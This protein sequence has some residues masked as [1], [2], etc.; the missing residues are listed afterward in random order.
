MTGAGGIAAR[1]DPAGALDAYARALEIIEGLAGA[2]GVGHGAGNLLGRRDRVPSRQ[3]R[4]G[5][6]WARSPIDT[7]KIASD[8]HKHWC[9]ILGLNQLNRLADSHE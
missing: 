9:T 6:F 8:L 2:D 4:L 1:G 5:T 3:S 7:S